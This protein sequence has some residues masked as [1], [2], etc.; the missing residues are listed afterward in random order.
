MVWPSIENQ[1]WRRFTGTGTGAL[2]WMDPAPSQSVALDCALS[3]I[4]RFGAYCITKRDLE[5]VASFEWVEHWDVIRRFR[6]RSR[7]NLA[8]NNP[9]VV[10]S[11][12]V[13]WCQWAS[14]LVVGVT[15]VMMDGGYIDGQIMMIQ[16]IKGAKPVKQTNKHGNPILGCNSTKSKQHVTCLWEKKSD[17]L[18]W[19]EGCLICMA[20]AKSW[21]LLPGCWRIPCK[22]LFEGASVLLHG[23]LMV[24]WPLAVTSIEG[25]MIASTPRSY[26][27]YLLRNTC[28]PGN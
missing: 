4:W 10:S 26:Y 15:V 17:V 28:W 13:A 16:R 23:A 24:L 21:G 25:K 3:L 19:N 11:T 2:K 18:R 20:A 7:S 27:W 14:V 1:H 5:S 22:E 8:V 6:S 9:S 12:S